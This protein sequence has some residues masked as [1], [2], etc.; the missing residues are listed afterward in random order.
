VVT[1]RAVCSSS[2]LHTWRL[3]GEFHSLRLLGELEF[4]CGWRRIRSLSST[5]II[6]M[7][8]DAHSERQGTVASCTAI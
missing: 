5:H 1:S 7:T 3:L 2:F 6:R 4:C 8:T